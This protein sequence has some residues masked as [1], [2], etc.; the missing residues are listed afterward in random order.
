MVD[1][2]FLEGTINLSTKFWRL[3]YT[4]IEVGTLHGQ[5]YITLSSLSTTL[6]STPS[7]VL[8]DLAELR[9]QN[10]TPYPSTRDKQKYA[11]CL[12][13]D[14]ADTALCTLSELWNLAP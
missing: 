10:S 11:P 9:Y 4:D 1:P 7:R 3:G 8:E 2:I 6:G 5:D 12:Y 13:L 14:D